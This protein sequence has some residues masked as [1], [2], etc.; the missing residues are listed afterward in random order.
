MGTFLYN[1]KTIIYICKNIFIDIIT[2][3]FQILLFLQKR[4]SKHGFSGNIQGKR[5]DLFTRS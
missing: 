4:Q 3:T 5:E 1:S 2:I